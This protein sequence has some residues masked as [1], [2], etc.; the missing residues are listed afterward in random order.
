MGRSE[1][2]VAPGTLDGESD[3]CSRRVYLLAN[4]VQFKAR[5]V[6]TW[7]STLSLGLWPLRVTWGLGGKGEK[8]QGFVPRM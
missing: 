4:M 6:E 1:G 3:V 2:R 7:T 5:G 8:A